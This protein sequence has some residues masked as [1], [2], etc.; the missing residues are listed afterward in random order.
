MR[1]GSAGLLVA[2]ATVVALG[3]CGGGG[4]EA[5]VADLEEAIVTRLADVEV[6]AVE[7]PEDVDL[8]EETLVECMVRFGDGEPMPFDVT[9]SDDG[10]W[11]AEIPPRAA[12]VIFE[13]EVA[14]SLGGA[15]G[16]E[17]TA[18]DCPELSEFVE[19]REFEC[20]GTAPAGD[21][22]V[23]EITLTD[24]QGGFDLYV[25]PEQSG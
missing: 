4:D 15:T 8:G 10:E 9:L 24:D 3:A 14:E 18:V 21:T 5:T 25:P 1:V 7:C 17:P 2:L 6:D 22:A 11:E 20:T 16:I 23:I 12:T 19:G 13:A